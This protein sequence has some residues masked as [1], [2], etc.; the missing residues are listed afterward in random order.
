MDAKT[1]ELTAEIAAAYAS[2]NRLAAADLPALIQSVSSAL[3]ATANPPPEPVEVRTP[4]V[5]IR[6]SV[7]PDFIV[8]LEDGRQFKSLKRHLQTRYGLTPEAYREK[9][10]LPKTYPMVAP[11]YAASRAALAKAMGLGAGGRGGAPTTAQAP[12]AP[13]APPIVET[14]RPAPAPRK[15]GRPRKPPATAAAPATKSPRGGKPIAPAD[16]DFT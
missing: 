14:A 4:A 3:M 7:Q 11:N 15:V 12:S 5:P 1:I 10:G 13:A 8:C 16:D 2:N 9:W 6:R